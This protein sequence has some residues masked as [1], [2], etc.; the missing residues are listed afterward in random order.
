MPDLSSPIGMFDSGVGGLAVLI[1]TRRLLPGE[2]V[3]YYADAAHFPYGSRHREEVIARSEAITE[4]LL[5]RGAKIIVVACN[6]ATSAAIS[7]LR[8]RF[9]VPFV[10]MEPALKPAA[11]RT[12]SGKVALLVTPQTADGQKLAALIDRFGA[13]VSVRT[14]PA[15]DLAERV[16]SGAVDDE[17]TRELL[18]QYLAPLRDE[19]VDVLALGCTHYAFLRPAIERELGDGVAVIE[20]SEAV[21]RQVKRVLD[22]RQLRNPR[23]QGGGVLYLTSGG[24][25]SFASIRGR[26][27]EAG[28]P[29]PD[30]AGEVAAG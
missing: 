10:G 27:R 1:E 22:G 2:D 12:M 25:R 15:P 21:A 14:V 23:A 28:V 17:R 4:D 29:V 18:R 5:A 8:E 16:E 6:S 26:L 9:D 7:H 30:D 24:A 3:I 11:E 19:A 13:E 20:P